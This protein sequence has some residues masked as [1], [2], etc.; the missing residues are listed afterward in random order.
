MLWP[1]LALGTLR[2]YFHKLWE[3]SALLQGQRAIGT[4]TTPWKCRTR[5]WSLT[6]EHMKAHLMC[7]SPYLQIRNGISRSQGFESDLL[8]KVLR[9][10]KWINKSYLN[11]IVNE[12][13]LKLYW[14]E[15]DSFIKR[16]KILRFGCGSF[17]KWIFHLI[18]L[19]CLI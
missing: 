3:L 19:I 16:I 15:F 14:F 4:T 8:L 13:G 1:P 12:F 5:S 17:I 2:P 6:S 18:R 9:M 11:W 7:L 10:A